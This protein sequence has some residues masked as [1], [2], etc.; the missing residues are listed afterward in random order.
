V[1]PLV[2]KSLC[3]LVRVMS[4][5]CR[6]DSSKRCFHNSCDVISELGVVSVCSL[7]RGGLKFRP[8]KFVGFCLSIFDL[9]KRGCGKRK[10]GSF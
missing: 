7:Y 6:F 4:K 3:R 9:L 1:F 10:R 5:R 2:V 8:R